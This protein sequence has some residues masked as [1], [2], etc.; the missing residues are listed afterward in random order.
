MRKTDRKPL[1]VVLCGHAAVARDLFLDA[2]DVAQQVN[3][4]ALSW[5]IVDYEIEYADRRVRWVPC[6]TAAVHLRG[7]KIRN[8]HVDAGVLPGQVIGHV[9]EALVIAQLPAHG[10]RD[11]T[12]GDRQTQQAVEGGGRDDTPAPAQREHR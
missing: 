7:M 2:R 9:M 3:H 8:V 10:W 11:W 12:W 4:D 1:D 5:R 6:A